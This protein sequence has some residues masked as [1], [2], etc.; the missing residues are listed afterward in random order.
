MAAL[1]PPVCDF[2]W[3]APDFNLPGT[4]GAMYRLSDIA[5]ASGTLIVFMCNHCPFVLAIL[6]RLL[7]DARDLEALGIGVAGI[8]S[9]DAVA[10]PE[11]SFEK[12]KNL[13]ETKGFPFPYLHDED[14]SVARAYDAVCTPDFF[15][16]NA[17]GGLQYRGR[18][19]A[20]RMAPAPEDA[21]RELFEAMTRVAETGRGPEA[22]TPSIGCSIKW[23]SAA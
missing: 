22:Q 18:L 2:N 1:T 21:P 7:R 14:Q 8:C 19:D 17:D 20:S 9:N 10:Y 11:D 12:M 4:D 13:A 15:G 16:F 23:R 3:P 6:D 5:G